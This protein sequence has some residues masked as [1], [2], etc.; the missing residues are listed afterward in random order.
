MLVLVRRIF[1]GVLMLLALREPSCARL[2]PLIL[3]SLFRICMLRN[4]LWI[5]IAAFVVVAISYQN[6]HMI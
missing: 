4:F 5:I 2:D 1:R 6:I 3:R